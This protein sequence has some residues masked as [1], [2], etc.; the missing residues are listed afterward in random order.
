MNSKGCS[1]TALRWTARGIQLNASP[2]ALTGIVD[3]GSGRFAMSRLNM[4]ASFLAAVAE[5]D[6]AACQRAEPGPSNTGCLLEETL[7][8]DDDLWFVLV[9][10]AS[11]CSPSFMRDVARHPFQIFSPA[12]IRDVV[13]LCATCRRAHARTSA[14]ASSYARAIGSGGNADLYPADQVPW[15]MERINLLCELP[16]GWLIPFEFAADEI[17]APQQWDIPSAATLDE[18]ASTL[19][20]HPGL[21]LTIEGHAR[22][23][24]P[25]AFGRPLS[26]AR[27][28]RLRQ[29]LLTRLADAPAWRSEGEAS[30]GVRAGGYVEG[31]GDFD[32][33]ASFYTQRVVGRRIRA[34]GVWTDD[35]ASVAGADPYTA[36]EYAKV[37]RTRR[38]PSGQSAY[39]A[40]LGFH[41]DA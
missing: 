22:P 40:V 35:D 8:A 17:E 6:A 9:H 2:A 39:V 27:A 3:G 20:R 33:V 19:R 37:L 14:T 5:R 7:V 13:N 30:E 38:S 1:Q 29:E 4:S 36:S 28:A 24:A 11:R 23:G 15:S 41:D 21:R 34:R 26:Q 18:I 32:D 25:A 16:K 12:F 10:P 31:E